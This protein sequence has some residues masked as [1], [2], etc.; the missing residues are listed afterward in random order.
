MSINYEYGKRNKLNTGKDFSKYDFRSLLKKLLYPIAKNIFS[1]ETKINE[2][3]GIGLTGRAAHARHIKRYLYLCK[4]NNLHGYSVTEQ[5]KQNKVNNVVDEKDTRM[6]Q[7]DE[8]GLPLYV[9]SEGTIIAANRNCGKC[10]EKCWKPEDF[11]NGR[12]W[13]ASYGYSCKVCK[14]KEPA[15]MQK[16]Q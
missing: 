11:P 13:S 14:E 6:E 16:K 5:P 2:L 1:I 3:F 4:L 12:F 15:E 9:F 8:N 7:K 10:G